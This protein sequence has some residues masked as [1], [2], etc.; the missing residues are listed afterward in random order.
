M[1]LEAIIKDYIIKAFV[2]EWPRTDFTMEDDLFENYI[3]N[4]ESLVELKRFIEHRFSISV[5][6]CELTPNNFRT[7][8]DI[9]HYIA[10]RLDNSSI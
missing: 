5:S 4:S 1:Q 8:Q 3:L 10:G 6:D 2:W 9:A 7:V